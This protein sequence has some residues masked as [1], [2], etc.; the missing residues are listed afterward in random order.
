MRTILLLRRI[1][2]LAAVAVASIFAGAAPA[3]AQ[4]VLGGGATATG[5]PSLAGGNNANAIGNNSTALG[6][7]STASGPRST[8]VGDS[9]QA[10]VNCTPF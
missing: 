5:S 9:A 2:L 1:A 6:N 7:T 4:V 3:Q 10:S 8:A